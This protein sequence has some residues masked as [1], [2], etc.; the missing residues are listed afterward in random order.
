MRIII[1]GG[2][3]GVGKATASAMAAAGHEVVIAC[4]SL[5]KGRDAVMSMSGDVKL[6]ELDLA[7]LA[8]VRKFADTIDWT[9]VLVNNAGVLGL[10][11]TRTA[12]GFEAHMGTNH[13]GHFALTCLLGDRIRDRVVV[14]ASS[15][16]ALARMHFDDLNWRRRRYNAWAAYGE[17]KLA[18]MLFV[19]ELARRGRIA[20]LSDPGMTDTGITQGGSAPLR[21]AGRVLAPRIAQTPAEGAR[22]TIQAIS[23]DLPNGSYIAPG[24]PLHQWGKPKAAKVITKARD[25]QSSR[26]LWE[27]SAELTGC[28]W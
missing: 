24:G 22:S 11:L 21:W 15:N 19:Y 8:S 23:T 26:R 1:T 28:D 27:I 25:P 17:S 4:R 7:D 13:L 18:N 12:D 6:A 20:Y 14:V 16:H 5:S 9:D 3:S 10:P 2:N